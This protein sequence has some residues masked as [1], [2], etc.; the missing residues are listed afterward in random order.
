MRATD[1][2]TGRSVWGGRPRAPRTGPGAGTKQQ[3]SAEWG[4]SRCKACSKEVPREARSGVHAVVDLFDPGGAGAF[5]S[6]QFFAQGLAGDAD[7]F[8]CLRLVSIRGL[9]RLR[10]EE[11]LH[12]PEAGRFEVL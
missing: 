7:K 11:V 3:R 1:A 10:D 2:C 8:G 4:N 12:H 5:E 9:E 6:L